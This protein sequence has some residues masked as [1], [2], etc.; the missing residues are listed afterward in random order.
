MK[1]NYLKKIFYLIGKEKKKLP[2]LVLLYLISSFLDIIG[3]GLIGPFISLFSGVGNNSSFFK[4]LLFIF[5]KTKPENYVVVVGLF[6]LSIFIL[7]TVISVFINKINLKFSTSQ[8]SNLRTLLMDTYQSM[9]YEKFI[10]YNSADVIQR[11]RVQTGEFI[12]N[13]LIPSL[14]ILSES[15][16]CFVILIFLFYISPYAM[17]LLITLLFILVLFYDKIIKS[18][19]TN[20][21]NN[22]AVFGS[23]MVKGIQEGMIGFKEIRI[24]GKQHYFKKI[25]QESSVLFSKSQEEHLFL[26]F[27]PRYLLEL[28]IISFMV[29]Y[30]I[31]L[32][33][34]G[35]NSDNTFS[36]MSIFGVSAIRLIPA[37]N[38]IIQSLTTLRYSKSAVNSIYHDFKELNIKSN[39]NHND[40][41]KENIKKSFES[42]ELCNISYK[43][44]NKNSYA[45]DN[46]NIKIS[47]GQSIGIVG[48]SGSGKTT[49]IDVLLCLLEPQQ[50]QIILNGKEAFNKEDL[51]N[52]FA[53]LP[54]QIFIINDTIKKNVALGIEDQNIDDILV[55]QSLKNA[56]LYELIESFPLGINTIL[57]ENG[58]GLS[59]GQR[60]RIALARA[61]YHNRDVIVMDESTSALDNETEKEIVENIQLFKGKK[62]L[63]IIAHRNS[64][65]KYCDVIFKLENG[66]II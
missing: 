16:I 32:M 65:L 58:I 24:L 28:V 20:A 62:T 25:V 19:I 26:T 18:K 55:F 3:I 36:V 64:T 12:Y 47:N 21:G 17:I 54:Q 15:I 35:G 48:T 31:S 52:H 13:C 23:L 6:L 14:R 40:N 7:K 43:Y 34:L 27:I 53:Y 5:P 39:K 60:Q 42:L 33:L 37:V 59:G 56:R 44:P 57:G 9:N 41:K 66:K 10:L 46:I 8:D 2:F 49:L 4:Y 1:I 50:G 29:F 11:I 61:F 30:P 51:M 45:L 38:I 22:S 63:I